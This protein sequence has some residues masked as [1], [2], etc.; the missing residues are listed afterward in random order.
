MKLGDLS[1][2]FPDAATL[3]A[4]AYIDSDGRY[5]VFGNRNNDERWKADTWSEAVPGSFRGGRQGYNFDDLP[6]DGSHIFAIES[7]SSVWRMLV[8]SSNLGDRGADYHS[9][10]GQDWAIADRSNGG[11][12]LKGDIAE[13]LIFNRA[14]SAT[15]MGKIGGYLAAK[16]GIGA[17]GWT[18]NIDPMAINMPDT[19]IHVASSTELFSDTPSTA[20]YGNLNLGGT[21]GVALTLTG[22]PGGTFFESIGFDIE[23]FTPGT[24]HDQMIFQGPGHPIAT[25]SEL[26]IL[27]PLIFGQDDVCNWAVLMDIEDPLVFADGIFTDARTGLPLPEGASFI[28]GNGAYFWQISYQYE[29][30]DVAIHLTGIPEPTT[31]ALLGLGAVALL[32]RRR[33]QA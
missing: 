15:E 19:D 27:T 5:N 17:A 8:D 7:N 11:Q 4:V 9:G 32:R 25:G 12:E 3:F 30:N 29:G 1:A 22:A 24:E 21:P 13:L 28:D 2:Q 20:T 16:Y 14:L 6:S 23:G 26:D 18:G 10:S 31:M 33:R